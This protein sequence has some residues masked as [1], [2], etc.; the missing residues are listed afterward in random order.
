MSKVTEMGEVSLQEVTVTMTLARF[1]AAAAMITPG[2]EIRRM[3]LLLGI[4]GE[5]TDMV[6]IRGE[7]QGYN[8]LNEAMSFRAEIDALS[9]RMMSDTDIAEARAELEAG[10]AASEDGGGEH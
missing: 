10:L 9:R 3:E 5:M 2:V 1:M 6:R 8:M 4:P 7:E